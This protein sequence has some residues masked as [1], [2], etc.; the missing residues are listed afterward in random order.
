MNLPRNEQRKENF[1]RDLSNKESS[2]RPSGLR[3]TK[4]RVNSLAH[5]TTWLRS[6]LA[7]GF[8]SFSAKISFGSK[9][10]EVMIMNLPRNEQR[11]E[12]FL[13]DLSNKESFL[14]RKEENLLKEIENVDQKISRLQESRRTFEKRLEDL[15]TLQAQNKQVQDTLR[16]VKFD[17]PSQETREERLQR[18][19]RENP[20]LAQLSEDRLPSSIRSEYNL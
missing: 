13:R 17:Q 7:G 5:R 4:S 18:L 20:S 1:L 8:P 6:D 19:Y 3:K 9:S 15:K 16:D 2:R 12:N 10:E 11:K 14:Q